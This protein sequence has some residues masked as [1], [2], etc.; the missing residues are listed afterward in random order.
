M[1]QQIE[2]IKNKL[3]PIINLMTEEE[4]EFIP[5]SQEKM[6][7]V[8]DHTLLKPE[9][10]SEQIIKLCEEAAE[11]GFASVC[12][13][14]IYVR[15]AAEK[16]AG[17]S[18]KVC[19]V[20]GFPLGASAPS[21]KVMEAANAMIDGAT[22]VDMVLPIGQLKSRDYMAVYEDIRGVVRVASDKVIVKVILETALLTDE[23]KIASCLLAK[24]AGADF[25][26]NSTGFGGG[27]ATVEDI[28]LMR[29][30][31]G[32]SMGIKASGAVRS[33]QDVLAMLA[34]GATRIGASSSV[35]I[36]QGEPSKANGDY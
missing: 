2:E 35:T 33:Q 17:S 7:S 21:V 9:A 36:V 12:V 15:L 27:G 26:K 10:T 32:P 4:G 1:R 25:V 28:K 3:E 11:L 24:K 5:L 34:A 22:E 19:T 31:V 30:T 6:A 23:E 18:V 29:E 14:P 13:N 20:I 16:L 8:I